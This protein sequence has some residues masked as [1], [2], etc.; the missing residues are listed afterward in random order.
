MCSHSDALQAELWFGSGE[1]ED[2]V[3][4]AGAAAAE[5]AGAAVIGTVAA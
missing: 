1:G 3:V 5:V 2:V 4:V